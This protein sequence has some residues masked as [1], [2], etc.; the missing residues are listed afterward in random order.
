MRMDDRRRNDNEKKQQS[1]VNSGHIHPKVVLQSER[2]AL[3][4]VN[5]L[6][7]WEAVVES[8]MCEH[9]KSSNEA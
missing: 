9:G 2:R 1:Q 8:S 7:L 5:L 4:T 3:Y 6:L